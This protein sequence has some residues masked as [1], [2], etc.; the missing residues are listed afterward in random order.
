MI[1]AN[2]TGFFPYTPGTNMLYALGEA[3]D[4]LH[5]E[6]LENV[7]ARTTATPRQRGAPRRHGASKFSARSRDITHRH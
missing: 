5:E 2:K 6:G 4:M 3:I 1:A 7:F